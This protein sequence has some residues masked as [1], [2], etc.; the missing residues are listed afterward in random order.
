ML[1]L[2]LSRRGETVTRE[3]FLETVW[4][5]HAF[6]STRTVDNFIAQLR[7]RIEPDVANPEHL[8]TI[9]GE[10]YRLCEN[11]KQSCDS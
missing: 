4:G 8:I 3:M 11:S 10:G 6:P 7:A 5:Y 2:L 9:R 1:K